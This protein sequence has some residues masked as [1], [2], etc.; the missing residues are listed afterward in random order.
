MIEVERAFSLDRRCRN[1]CFAMTDQVK[2][3]ATEPNARQEADR[4]VS[5]RYL[6]NEMPLLMDT[7]AIVI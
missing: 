4:N 7:A 5:V 1:D 6:L 3:V 2:S